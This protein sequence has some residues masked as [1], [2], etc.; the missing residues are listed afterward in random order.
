MVNPQ[1]CVVSASI[2]PGFQ[3][4]L[5][6]SMHLTGPL[7]SKRAHFWW[8]HGVGDREHKVHTHSQRHGDHL[9]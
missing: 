7:H 9:L 4:G 1:P 5:L 3:E 8:S 6:W 2:Q